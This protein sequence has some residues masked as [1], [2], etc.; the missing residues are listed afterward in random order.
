VPRAKRNSSGEDRRREDWLGYGASGRARR[1]ALEEELFGPSARRRMLEALET[2]IAEE[3]SELARLEDD[4]QRQA[5]RIARSRARLAAL[6]NTR[7][8]RARLAEAVMAPSLT[9]PPERSYAL[10]RC[11]GFQVDSPTGKV[12]VVEGLRYQSRI[13]QPDAL[14]V[15]A[16]WRRRLLLIPVDDVDQIFVDEGR[17]AVNMQPAL[18]HDVFH[19]LMARLRGAP[20]GDGNARHHSRSR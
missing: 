20:L 10:C 19:E 2:D 11:E 1:W 13:D 9:A 8:S 3:Q 6:R 5:Q 16:G 7:S 18:R 17:L 14:E 15:R 4:V 12:G